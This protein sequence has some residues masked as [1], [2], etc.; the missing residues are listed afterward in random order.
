VKA[1]ESAP[2]TPPAELQL[3][4]C[5]EWFQAGLDLLST[6]SPIHLVYAKDSAK[7][8][9]FQNVIHHTAEGPHPISHPSLHIQLL[10]PILKSSEVVWTVDTCGVIA[11]GH[12]ACKAALH[13]EKVVALAGEGIAPELR[14]FYRVSEGADLRSILSSDSPSSRLISGDPLMGE[15]RDIDGHLGFGHTVL[16]AIPEEPTRKALHFFR[17]TSPS[18][19][20]TKTYE[21]NKTFSTRLHGEERAFIDPNIYDKVMPLQI[22]TVPLIKALLAEDFETAEILGSLEVAPEDFALPTFICPSKIEMVEIVRKGLSK[23]ASEL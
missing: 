16:C 11:I 22:S 21:Q 8:S 13:L 15:Q 18:Y 9:Q 23:I 7:F 19:T 20:A 14:G 2:F 4:N 6:I 1:I 5:E 12:A 17:W 3:E 10:D